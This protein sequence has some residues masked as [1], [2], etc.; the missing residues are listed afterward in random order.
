MPD[1]PTRSLDEVEARL[2]CD[3]CGGDDCWTRLHDG[4]FGSTGCGFRSWNHAEGEHLHHG[5]RRCG[6][7][8]TAATLDALLARTPKETK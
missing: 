5:C 7:D 1:Q 6:W 2:R 3:K 4:R 8:W